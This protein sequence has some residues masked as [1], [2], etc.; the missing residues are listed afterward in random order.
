MRG[1]AINPELEAMREFLSR[2]RGGTKSK[3]EL[4]R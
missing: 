4:V 3:I 1:F 2:Y